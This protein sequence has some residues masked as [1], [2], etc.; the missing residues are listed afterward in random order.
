MRWWSAAAPRRPDAVKGDAGVVAGT[1]G[2]I[3]D[4][5]K[6]SLN[7]TAM[8][9][10][11]LVTGGSAFLGINLVRLLLGTGASVRSLDIAPFD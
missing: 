4:A 11:Y 2:S 8:S 3:N 6:V 7:A 5:W 10:R 9:N 1:Y